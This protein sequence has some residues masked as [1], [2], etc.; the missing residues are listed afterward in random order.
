MGAWNFFLSQG[1]GTVSGVLEAV[2]WGHLQE[3][4]LL[5]GRGSST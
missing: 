5:S 1:P 2:I 4:R 3:H